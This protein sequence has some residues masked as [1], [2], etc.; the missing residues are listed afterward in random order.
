MIHLLL[1]SGTG[2]D[3]GSLRDSVADNLSV[4]TQDYHDLEQIGKVER[5]RSGLLNG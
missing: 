2:C 3:A 1:E 4:L 5:Q